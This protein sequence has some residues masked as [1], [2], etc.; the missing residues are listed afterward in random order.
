MSLEYVHWR[1]MRS[2]VM[3]NYYMQFDRMM[4]DRGRPTQHCS[5]WRFTFRWISGAICYA[6]DCNR[7]TQKFMVLGVLFPF[8][9]AETNRPYSYEVAWTGKRQGFRSAHNKHESKGC[10]RINT[11]TTSDTLATLK[12][13]FHGSPIHV[14]QMLHINEQHLCIDHEMEV[15]PASLVKLD[16]FGDSLKHII[17]EFNEPVDS[18]EIAFR[19]PH[20]Q[21]MNCSFMG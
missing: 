6:S 20:H 17:V 9:A 1:Y 3:D 10:Y 8:K 12:F 11:A 2:P 18:I 4:R 16:R 5:F 7:L 19:N 21:A 15:L 14:K 13:T